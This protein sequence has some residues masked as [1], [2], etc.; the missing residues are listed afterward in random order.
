MSSSSWSHTT[1]IKKRAWLLVYSP[2]KRTFAANNYTMGYKSR[3]RHKSRREKFQDVLR[4]TRVIILFMF[5]AL[6][7][8]AYMNRREIWAWLKTYWYG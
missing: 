6:L 4:N 5:I 2:K 7:L 1:G 3:K 8:Y